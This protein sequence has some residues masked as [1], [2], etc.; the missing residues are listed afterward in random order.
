MRERRHL[1]RRARRHVEAILVDERARDRARPLI[2]RLLHLLERVVLLT[3]GEELV[4]LLED[5]RP[6]RFAVSRHGLIGA[7]DADAAAGIDAL[8][9]TSGVATCGFKYCDHVRYAAPTPTVSAVIENVV[10][11]AFDRNFGGGPVGSM[12]AAGCGSL[13]TIGDASARLGWPTICAIAAWLGDACGMLPGCVRILRTALRRQRRAHRPVRARLRRARPDLRALPRRSRRRRT[14]LGARRF[15]VEALARQQLRGR[16]DVRE[17]R[18]AAEVHRRDLRRLIERL[19]HRV[20]ELFR[21]LEALVRIALER[22]PEPLVERRRQIGA[23]LARHGERRR[24]DRRE[25]HRA[26][27]DRCS[28]PAARSGT[29]TPCT[30]APR[31]RRGDRRSPAPS[32]AR[33]TCTRAFRTPRLRG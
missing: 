5:R 33:A 8:D 29:R 21:R 1:A 6:L 3:G 12:F 24:G 19:R 11:S 22:L 7:L 20:G 4:R 17:V 32:P 2:H 23:H 27:P 14:R 10:R 30:R 25:R 16:R 28:T 13:V 9:C 15:Q 26:R 18:L 31:D